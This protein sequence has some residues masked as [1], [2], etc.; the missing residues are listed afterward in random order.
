MH[1]WVTQ[2]G[3]LIEARYFAGLVWKYWIKK[4]IQLYQCKVK[5]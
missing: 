1:R 3:H 2:E 5:G 4:I